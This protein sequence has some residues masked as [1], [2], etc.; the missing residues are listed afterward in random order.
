MTDPL[1]AQALADLRSHFPDLRWHIIEIG[2]P[3][4]ICGTNDLRGSGEIRVVAERTP[5]ERSNYAHVRLFVSI[6]GTAHETLVEDPRRLRAVLRQELQALSA[7][8]RDAALRVDGLVARHDA[9]K[10]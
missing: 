4:D 10:E 1:L 5:P 3:R 8:L 6:G 9:R 7:D 2:G